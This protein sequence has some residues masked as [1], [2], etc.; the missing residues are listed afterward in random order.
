M[1]FLCKVFR[2]IM[3]IL[4]HHGK[5]GLLSIQGVSGCFNLGFQGIGSLQVGFLGF[6][7]EARKLEHHWPHALTVKYKES[8]H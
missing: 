1:Q 3:Y 6:T 5:T 4:Q 8:Q 7:V 2:Y